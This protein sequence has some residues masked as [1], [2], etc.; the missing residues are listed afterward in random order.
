MSHY[1]VEVQGIV[2]E[3]T[4][5]W[6]DAVLFRTAQG[7][8]GDVNGDGQVDVVDVSIVINTAL[9]SGNATDYPSD[10]DVNGDG[11][12]DVVDVNITIN[13]ALGKD[14]AANYPAVADVRGD[15]LPD[16][17]DGNAITGISPLKK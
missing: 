15:V 12:V 6:T 1:E 9:E 8:R 3:Q 14:S 11:V 10:A 2:G 17:N 16:V 13:I 7:L 5:A 4:T